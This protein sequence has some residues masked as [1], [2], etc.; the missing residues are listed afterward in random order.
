MKSGIFAGAIAGVIMGIGSTILAYILGIL[1][2]FIEPIGGLE[3]W[4]PSM[5]ILLALAEISLGL[6]WGSIFGAIYSYTHNIIPGKGIIKGLYFGLIILLI[7]DIAA[8]S[9]VALMLMQI[10]TAINLIIYGFFMWIIYG[11]ILGYLY[12]KE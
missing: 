2:Q 3:I 11:L 6:I 10:Q 12:K 9:Y 4:D 8:G 1:L 5:Q 7:K